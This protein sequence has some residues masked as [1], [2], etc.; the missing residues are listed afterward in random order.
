MYTPKRSVHTHVPYGWSCPN[1]KG[2]YGCVGEIESMLA[3]V[4]VHQMVGLA[5]VLISRWYHS[6]TCEGNGSVIVVSF[7]KKQTKAI[8]S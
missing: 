2:Y 7:T 4:L 5:I 3:E 1:V 8:N 6:T